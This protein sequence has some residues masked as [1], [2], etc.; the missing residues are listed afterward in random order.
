MNKIVVSLILGTYLCSCTRVPDSIEP[1]IDYA[2]QDRYLQQLPPAFSPLT[3]LEKKEPWGQEMQ[4]GLGFAHE[5]DLYQAATTF[6]RALYLLPSS[7][8]QRKQELDYEIL[9]C[10]YVAKKYADVIKTYETT[11]LRFVDSSFPASHDLLVILLDSYN[12]TQETA[13][14]T[15]ILGYLQQCY[16]ETA[17]KLRVATYLQEGNISA[18]KTLS[19]DPSYDYIP[20]LL[21]QYEKSKKSVQT[22]Q[23]LNATLPGAGYLYI[24]QKQSA[25]T[26]LLL[27]GLFIGASY[28]FFHVGNIPAGIIFAGFESGWYF[29]GIYGVAQETKFYNER[30][31]ERIAS[32]VMNQQK[33]FPILTLQHAF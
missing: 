6:K 32:P 14:A 4:I 23:I 27:N 12:H 3:P 9:L 29:G 5:L 8:R 20:P 2:V 21:S 11:D 33:L 17:E 15:R 13:K 16:P 1:K 18:L 22:A 24:G 19:I 30:V 26:A 7:E 28:Y 10:Y 25:F 31:Y